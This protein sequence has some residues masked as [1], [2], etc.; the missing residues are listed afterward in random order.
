MKEKR[1]TGTWNKIEHYS[2]STT[3][4]QWVFGGNGLLTVS[5]LDD[6]TSTELAEINTGEW[7]V[8]QKVS[9]AYLNI[10]FEN[11]R[12]GHYGFYEIA[13]IK[14]DALILTVQDGGQYLM[15]FEKAD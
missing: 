9:K 14:K 8:L 4:E 2:A 10:S 7:A 15:E 5:L 1:L 11:E 6:S 13:K 12:S 3:T